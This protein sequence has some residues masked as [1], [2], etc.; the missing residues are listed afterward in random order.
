MSCFTVA[1]GNGHRA[2]TGTGIDPAS[3]AEQ[4]FSGNVLIAVVASTRLGQH[5]K[6]LGVE[7]NDG[8]MFEANPATGRP[9]PQLFVDAFPGHAE[10][11]RAH[12]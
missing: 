7:D 8:A 9:D 11:G 12:V 6:R 5:L 10:I 1:V 2:A 3:H 4:A